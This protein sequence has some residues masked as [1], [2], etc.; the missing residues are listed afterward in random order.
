MCIQIADC[1]FYLHFVE[2]NG[3]GKSQLGTTW[4][5]CH[6][7]SP[8][9]SAF[10]YGDIHSQTPCRLYHLSQ[11]SRPLHTD[12]SYRRNMALELAFVLGICSWIPF[13]GYGCGQALI[14][15]NTRQE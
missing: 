3:R 5:L 13:R 1:I 10:N 7:S 2:L 12:G 8:T 4:D 14:I 11:I 9:I 6:T 15:T